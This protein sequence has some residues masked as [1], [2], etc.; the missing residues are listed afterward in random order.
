MS[1]RSRIE[2]PGDRERHRLPGA[3][4]ALLLL[5]GVVLFVGVLFNQCSVPEANAKGC[6]T[7]SY[8]ER[9]LCERMYWGRNDELRK[10][11]V[12]A[13]ESIAASLKKIERKMK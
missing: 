4:K 13:L 1:Q 9:T 3:Y 6:G 2:L 5:I 8:P 10:R 11:E 12:K 7:L